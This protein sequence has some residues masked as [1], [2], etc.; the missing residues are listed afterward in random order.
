MTRPPST[1]ATAL[2]QAADVHAVLALINDELAEQ[3][4]KTAFTLLAFDARRHLILGRGVEKAVDAQGRAQIALDHLPLPVRQALLGGQQF[5]DVGE[6]SVQYAKLLG[7]A[8]LDDHCRLYLRGLVIDNALAAVLAATDGRRR[9]P[10]KILERLDPLAA[11]FQLA[12]AR[13]HER[14]ARFEAVTALHEITT[15]LRATHTAAVEE[16]ERE[17]ARLRAAR[18]DVIDLKRVEQ[19]EAAADNAK[20]RAATAERRLAAVEQQVANAVERL[21]RAHMQLHQQT[22]TLQVQADTIHQLE[23]QLVQLGVEPHAVEVPHGTGRTP[24]VPLP[25]APANPSRT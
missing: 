9:V 11:L 21:E 12:F 5:A 15:R 23:R 17:I 1:L 22:E 10:G 20:R 6:Q 8:A 25:A 7:I 2:V 14:D 24:S 19:L 4:K 16:R 18:G 3:D 13:F